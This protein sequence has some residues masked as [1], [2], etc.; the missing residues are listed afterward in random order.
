MH[1]C[2]YILLS[3]LQVLMLASHGWVCPP[4]NI[5]KLPTPLIYI[6]HVQNGAIFVIMHGLLNIY[7]AGGGGAGGGGGGGGIQGAHS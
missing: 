5:E 3:P 2:M 4:L 6:G 7:G 1:A